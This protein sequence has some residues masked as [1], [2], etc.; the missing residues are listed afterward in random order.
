[1]AKPALTWVPD[2]W[3]SASDLHR[4]GVATDLTEL[5]SVFDLAD[6]SLFGRELV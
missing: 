5:R 3:P 1:M 6:Y 4:P 2:R